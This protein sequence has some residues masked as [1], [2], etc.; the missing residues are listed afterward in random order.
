MSLFSACLLR[1]FIMCANLAVFIVR[2]LGL[3]IVLALM[4]LVGSYPISRCFLFL[5]VR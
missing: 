2:G 3:G 4:V 1:L 5:V